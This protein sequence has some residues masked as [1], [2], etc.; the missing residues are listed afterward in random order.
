MIDSLIRLDGKWALITGAAGGL[1]HVF[2]ETLAE[3]GANLYL[4]D[5]PESNFMGLTNEIRKRWAVEVIEL[6]YD[7]EQQDQRI[8]LIHEVK[9]FDS[10]LSILI[11]NAAFVGAASLQGW[12]V[13]F[14]D[15]SVETWR[16][17]FE[18]N[19]TAVFELTQG[20]APLLA[21]ANGGNIVNVASIYGFSG[22]DWRLYEGT[23]M[24][25]PAAYSASK[26]GII[27]FTRWLSTTL[28][29]KIRVNTL[30]P[31]GIVRGQPE[32]FISRYTNQTPLKRM[33]T[34]DDFRG[35]IAYL[36][37]NLSQYVTGQNLVVDGGW[38]VW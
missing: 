33:A 14:A 10:G 18:V 17:A 6:K 5:R 13:P 20:F 15:Q 29:P 7:L 8:K 12:T 37:T 30:S 35:A 2:S 26:G 32:T 22:P 9:T 23:S 36:T 38:S 19:L 21:T 27:Q 31:G 4:V 3:L 1:G 11:N 16:R 28:A 25:N 24:G 34:E